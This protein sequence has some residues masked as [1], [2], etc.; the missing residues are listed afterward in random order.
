MKKPS[1]LNGLSMICQTVPFD[2]EIQCSQME[3]FLHNTEKH[4]NCAT[5]CQIFMLSAITSGEVLKYLDN[6]AEI[7]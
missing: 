1:P 2:W 7:I 4:A 6:I 5:I 3:D